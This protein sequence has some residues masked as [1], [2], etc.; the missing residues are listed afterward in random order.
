MEI[1]QSNFVALVQNFENN[2]SKVLTAL[3]TY[4]TT[5]TTFLAA[6]E[7]GLNKAEQ[8]EALARKSHNELAALGL[9]REDLPRFVMFGK[10]THRPLAQSR[11][12][13]GRGE[14]CLSFLS[15]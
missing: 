4:F 12:Q 3:T 5:L 14:R 6:L 1:A 7:E 10:C 9:S 8:Y 15:F 11:C 13:Q 2:R